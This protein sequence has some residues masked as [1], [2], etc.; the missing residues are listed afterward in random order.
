M[1][2]VCRIG[3]VP[4]GYRR[5]S[6]YVKI[7]YE[8]GKL[9]ISGVIGPLSSG[10]ALGSCGQID[11]DFDHGPASDKHGALSLIRAGEIKFAK[12]WDRDKWYRFLRIWEYWHLNDMKAGCEHQREEKWEE[13][14]IDPKELPASHANRDERGIIA[15]WVYKEEHPKGLLA[16][17][18]P[19]CGYKYGTAWRRVDVPKEV[20]EFLTAL[21]E[22]DRTPAWV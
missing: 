11:M 15:T 21:P 7:K 4:C 13:R 14:R 2:K 1:K 9:S 3:L 19:V 5:A 17:P 8:E 20:I 18:C 22:A 16:E 10:N 6:C 12:G